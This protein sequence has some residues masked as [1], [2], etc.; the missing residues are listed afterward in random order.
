VV[1]T[2]QKEWTRL[3]FIA[4]Q[5]ATGWTRDFNIVVIDLSIANHSDMPAYKG[6]VKTRPF[7]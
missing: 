5:C 4:V 2:L 7:A 1:I 3:G 6:D